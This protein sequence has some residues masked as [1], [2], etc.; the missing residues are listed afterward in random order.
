MTPRPR[1]RDKVVPVSIG[2]PVSLMI[3]LDNELNWKQSRSL[4]V[5]KAIISRLDNQPAIFNVDSIKLVRELYVRG[6]LQ[7]DEYLRLKTLTEETVEEQ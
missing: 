7:T 2:I 1:S 3:R 5:K 6:I 4:W